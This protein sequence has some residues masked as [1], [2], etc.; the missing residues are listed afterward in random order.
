MAHR[1]HPR[2]RKPR[3]IGGLDVSLN[4]P[5]GFVSADGGDLAGRTT[6][7]GQTPTGGLP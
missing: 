4:L 6:S 1:F 7:L 5:Q 3:L 2:T